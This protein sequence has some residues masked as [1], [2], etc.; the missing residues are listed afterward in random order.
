MDDFPSNVRA[1][2][3]ERVD[4][5]HVRAYVGV[6][7]IGIE[8]LE[9]TRPTSAGAWGFEPVTQRIETPGDPYGL[10]IRPADSS[11]GLPKSLLVSDAFGGL[12]VYGEEEMAP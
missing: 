9:L 3:V 4:D 1:L 8:I 12:R 5:N 11:H 7:G 2:A 6:P 10:T